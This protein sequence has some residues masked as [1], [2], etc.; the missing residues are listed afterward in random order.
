MNASRKD[1]WF[2]DN[3]LWRA[4]TPLMFQKDRGGDATALEA[5]T[6]SRALMICRLV[7]L[8]HMPIFGERI[9]HEG[10]S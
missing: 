8:P 1:E 9:I 2:E 10:D 6:L 5:Y 3:T 7:R 4:L